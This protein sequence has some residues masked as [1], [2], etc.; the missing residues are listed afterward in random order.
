MNFL[1]LHFLHPLILVFFTQDIS[2]LINKMVNFKRS[3]FA[4]KAVSN[5]SLQGNRSTMEVTTS[6]T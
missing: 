6:V 5:L 4:S 3:N 2:A 1:L